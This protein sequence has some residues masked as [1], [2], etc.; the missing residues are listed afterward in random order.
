V[1]VSFFVLAEQV[2]IFDGPNSNIG[3]VDIDRVDEKGREDMMSDYGM[4]FYCN[5]CAYG[6]ES[7]VD[8]MIH[9]TTE[10]HQ[11]N[12]ESTIGQVEAD[13]YE[14]GVREKVIIVHGIPLEIPLLD[15]AKFFSTWGGLRDIIYRGQDSEGFS[16]SRDSYVNAMGMQ[17]M[18]CIIVFNDE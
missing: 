14:S 4:P 5:L 13:L 8:W 7:Y 17:T 16:S 15:V 10:A 11:T 3:F 9:L 6:I 2:F 18:R 12:L 1:Y